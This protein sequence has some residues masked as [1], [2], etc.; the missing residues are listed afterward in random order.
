VIGDPE[1]NI[2]EFKENLEHYDPDMFRVIFHPQG[3]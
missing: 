3:C 2:E 1:K